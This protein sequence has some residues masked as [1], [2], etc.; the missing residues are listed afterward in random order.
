MSARSSGLMRAKLTEN[1]QADM[2][3]LHLVDGLVQI[4][5]KQAP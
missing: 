2:V 5:F 1:F 3:A 4:F